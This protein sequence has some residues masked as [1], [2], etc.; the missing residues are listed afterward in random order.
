MKGMECTDFRDGIQEDTA[1][2]LSGIWSPLFIRSIRGK[3]DGGTLDLT[4]STP[5][6]VNDI[7]G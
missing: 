2:T 1:E 5:T 4:W 3:G 7:V 6:F